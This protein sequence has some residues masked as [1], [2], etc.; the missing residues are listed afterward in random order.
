MKRYFLIVAVLLFGVNAIAQTAA[1]TGAAGVCI[2]SLTTLSDAS[3]G[4]SW[5]SS[6]PSVAPISPSSG[7]VTGLSVGVATITYTVGSSSVTYSDSS[8]AVTGDHPGFIEGLCWQHLR[9]QCHTNWR[10]M[11]Q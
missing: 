1:I 4:G 8:K 7:V 6:N 2:G 5:S 9:T 11:A 3:P 10:R